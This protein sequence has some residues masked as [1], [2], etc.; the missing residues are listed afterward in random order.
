[1]Q[2]DIASE[3]FSAIKGDDLRAFE[4]HMIDPSAKDISFGR[5]PL[6]TLCYM[7]NANKIINRYESVLIKVNN[8]TRIDENIEMYLKFKS[9]AHRVLRL[10]VGDNKIVSP[11]EMLCILGKASKLEAL[12]PTTPKNA[13]IIENIKLIE[14]IKTSRVIDIGETR[15]VMPKQP[16]TKKAK[17]MIIASC[18][19]AV[20]M[21]FIC[22]GVIFGV[23]SFGIG[24][25]EKPYVVY[26]AKQFNAAIATNSYVILGADIEV[27]AFNLEKFDGVLNGNGYT[28]TIVNQNKTLVDE[29]N[30]TIENITIKTNVNISTLLDL[31]LLTKKNKGTID[32]VTMIVSGQITYSGTATTTSVTISPMV[33]DNDASITNTTVVLDLNAKGNKTT[34]VLFGGIA[35]NNDGTIENATVEGQVN[36]DHIN[37]ASIVCENAKDIKNSQSSLNIYQTT[38]ISNASLMI[39][40]IAVVNTGDIDS[41]E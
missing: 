20:L 17:T 36:L 37:G 3:L 28:L 23:Q 19:I 5:F 14:Q 25:E 11:L 7:Y 22:V 35:G 24:T 10:Y 1:M 8:Y 39:C 16:M 40:G 29:L 9:I 41:C 27:E 31:G 26:N 32:K 12:Y 38:E 21:V 15:I 30:G 34:D 33:V 2:D 4:K 6:L 13:L 18:A